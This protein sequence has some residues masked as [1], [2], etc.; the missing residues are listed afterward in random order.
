MN[1]SKNSIA[2]GNVKTYLQ[3]RV[4]SFQAG[5]LKHCLGKWLEFSSDPEIIKTVSGL[6]VEFVE[7]NTGCFSTPGYQYPKSPNLVEIISNEIT[8]LLGN[9]VIVPS[10]RENNEVISPIFVR[11]KS[12]NTYR[13]ILNLKKIE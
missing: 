4:K 9:E 12:D 3:G 1:V 11:E 10:Y 2:I 5:C 8:K 6:K 13:L 7:Q